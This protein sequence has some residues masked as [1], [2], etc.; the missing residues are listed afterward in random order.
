LLLLMT[1]TFHS[2][3][4]ADIAITFDLPFSSYFI[5]YCH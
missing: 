2:L 5:D 4:I 3:I 1:L